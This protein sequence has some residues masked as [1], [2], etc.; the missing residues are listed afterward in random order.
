MKKSQLTALRVQ[1]FFKAALLSSGRD[2]LLFIKSNTTPYAQHD[3]C[4]ASCCCDGSP[5]A[6][7]VALRPPPSTGWSC[8]DAVSAEQVLSRSSRWGQINVE[9]FCVH[10]TTRSRTE[11][12]KS[13]DLLFVFKG[14]LCSFGEDIQTLKSDIYSINEAMIQTEKQAVLRGK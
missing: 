10:V 11:P 3:G 12:Q 2:K 7:V 8:C 14:A 5:A 6:T 13:V 9:R 4:E 1:V